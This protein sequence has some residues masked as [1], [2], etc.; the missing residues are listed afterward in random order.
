MESP[1]EDEHALVISLLN[2]LILELV[3]LEPSTPCGSHPVE[4]ADGPCIRVDYEE[5]SMMVEFPSW[6]TVYDSIQKWANHKIWLEVHT[7]I[8][9]KIYSLLY[10]L[11]TR[12]VRLG[13]TGYSRPACHEHDQWDNV[14]DFKLGHPCQVVFSIVVNL[15][16][17]VAEV[18][19][20]K[21]TPIKSVTEPTLP[22]A[23]CQCGGLG[24]CSN[25][26]RVVRCNTVL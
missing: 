15:C 16:L 8:A 20:C 1:H 11:Q 7:K 21:V 18:N 23:N 2:V 6:N 13:S 10:L 22:S 25:P 3:E 4:H 17:F 5:K 24:M 19:C 14:C 26:C 12:G 9:N